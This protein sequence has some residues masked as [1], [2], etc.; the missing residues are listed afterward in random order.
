MKI[1]IIEDEKRTADGILRLIKQYDSSSFVMGV[2]ESVEEGVAWFN[3]RSMD[4]DLLLLDIQLTDGT[5]FEIF[6]KVNTEIPV[7]FITAYNEFA[8]QSFRLNSIDY[9]LKPIDFNDL[10]KAFDKFRRL[11]ENYIRLTYNELK[12]FL[13]PN[14]KSYKKRFLV[15][16]GSSIKCIM[17]SEIGYFQ[18]DEGLVIAYLLD[19]GK[20][21]IDN[22]L[23]ELCQMLD[24]AQ[25]FHI[26]R[27][28]IVNVESIQKISSYFNRR[29]ILRLKPGNNE[30]IVSRERVT[31][32]KNWLNA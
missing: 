10:K 11:K 20:A 23:A 1:L 13:T 24:P 31:D 16:S 15:K 29:V 27:K 5:S 26:N 3:N 25:F 17:A 28:S 8:I 32:F 4:P 7:I 19:G 2:I 18:A 14:Q 22:S 21:I 12:Y 6:E 30:A 9:L